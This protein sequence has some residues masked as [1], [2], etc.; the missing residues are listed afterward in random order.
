MGRVRRVRMNP[1]GE[2]IVEVELR[3]ELVPPLRTRRRADLEVD[4]D[5]A[6]RVPAGIDGREPRLAILIGGLRAAQKAQRRCVEAGI[7][8][9]GIHAI[10][11]TLPDVYL[12]ARESGAPVARH[13]RHRE[14]QRELGA[15]LERARGWF[16]ADVAA[17]QHLVHEVRPLGL[18]RPND[19][20]GER[21]DAR[22]VG[23][24]Q[25][26][27]PNEH[28]YP[29]EAQ[30]RQQLAAAQHPAHLIVVTLHVT[31]PR[32]WCNSRSIP[33]GTAPDQS[34]PGGIP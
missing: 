15:G 20:G 31:S 27:M 1:V 8:H 18:R 4:V 3:G 19:A 28:A 23:R 13:A 11:V 25:E 7:A 32:E 14:C 9:A 34:R 6:T 33:A 2:R 29:S 24:T 5:R 22:G 30:Q 10:G 26:T 12:R 17:L 16:G 21:N